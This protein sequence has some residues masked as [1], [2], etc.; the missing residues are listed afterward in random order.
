VKRRTPGGCR[1]H[2]TRSAVE[3]FTSAVPRRSA[4]RR[5]AVVRLA[6]NA[7]SHSASSLATSPLDNRGIVRPRRRAGARAC[8]RFRAAWSEPSPIDTA[9]P[10]SGSTPSRRGD[11]SSEQ[12]AMKFPSLRRRYDTKVI[13]QPAAQYLVHP[14]GLSDVPRRCKDSHQQPVAALSV[15]CKLDECSP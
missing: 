8:R 15:G 3:P 13:P 11:I 5:S 9:A 10:R 7:R 4:D 12:S 1:R 2:L 14:D 6:S